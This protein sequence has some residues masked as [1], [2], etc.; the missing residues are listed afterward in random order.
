M[1]ACCPLDFQTHCREGEAAEI[2][3]VADHEER[4]T[5]LLDCLWGKLLDL[6]WSEISD[7]EIHSVKLFGE[8]IAVVAVGGEEERENHT[9]GVI[10]I[11][12]TGGTSCL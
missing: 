3:L 8:P 11:L 10:I 1:T 4:G 2:E 12:L 6:N 9:G 7:V 5:D